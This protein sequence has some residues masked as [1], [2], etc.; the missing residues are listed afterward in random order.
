MHDLVDDCLTQ[1]GEPGK[2]AQLCATVAR[3]LMG[4]DAVIA[5]EVIHGGIFKSIASQFSENGRPMAAEFLGDHRDADASRLPARDLATLIHV[6]LRVSAFHVPFL[7][8][9]KPLLSIASRTSSLNP[10]PTLSKLDKI[11]YGTSHI[12]RRHH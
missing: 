4:R 12:I 11:D 6:D 3:L 9:D 1:L 7:A 5:V 2:L 8:S 10:P